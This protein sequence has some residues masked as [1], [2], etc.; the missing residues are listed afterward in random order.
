MINLKRRF[1][2]FMKYNNYDNNTL[3]HLQKLELMIL[4]DFI[5]ICEDNNINYFM[6]GGSLLGAIRHRGFIPWD[7]DVDVIMLR[8]DYEK[9][10]EIYN[11]HPL[12]KYDLLTPENTT[13]YFLLFSKLVL[14]GTK[15]EEWW[16]K[17]VNFNLGIFMDI[18]IL[19]TAPN[20]KIIQ[21]LH[22]YKVRILNRLISI[23]TLKYEN[24][25]KM[26]QIIVNS[27]HSIFKF[28]KIS[29][30][31]FKKKT[32]KLLKKYEDT[33]SNYVF[34]VAATLFPPIHLKND[35]MPPKKIK[36]EDTIVNIP[37]NYKAILKRTYGDNYMTLPPKEERYNH[38]TYNLDFGIYKK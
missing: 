5:Q 10:V 17:Q 12:E 24:Y 31:Y 30:N 35:Y 21:K 7:D 15:F 11:K 19:D 4:K 26:T 14:N 29:P 18:F 6:C 16:D 1:G 25:P 13:D 38:I 2:G 3:K 23:S 37:N 33:N 36:F 34:D 27:L 28:L 9:F 32:I 22:I 20:N 8:P